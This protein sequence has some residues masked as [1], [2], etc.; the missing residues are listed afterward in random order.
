MTADMTSDIDEAMRA[1]EAAASGGYTGLLNQIADRVGLRANARAVFGDPVD[2][3]GITVIPVAKVRWGFGG[4]GGVAADEGEANQGGGGGGGVSASPLG[5][6]EVRDGRAEFVRI[7]DPVAAW[8]LV[9]ASA[10]A[11]WIAL[12]GLRALF[13]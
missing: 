5:Y 6:I 1:A 13:R 9:V 3:E 4:G 2:R 12:R 10:V 8:P 7:N 11:A